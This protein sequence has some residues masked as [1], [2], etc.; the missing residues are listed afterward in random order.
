MVIHYYGIFEQERGGGKEN[1]TR[2]NKM[3]PLQRGK[4]NVTI[5]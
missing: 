1:E 4:E 5:D 3:A 2:H